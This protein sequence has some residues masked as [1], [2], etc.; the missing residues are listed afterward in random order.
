MKL[1]SK[2]IT[3]LIIG[4]FILAAMWLNSWLIGLGF[5]ALIILGIIYAIVTL[6]GLV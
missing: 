5:I 1:N 6:K 4:A 3:M 2:Q